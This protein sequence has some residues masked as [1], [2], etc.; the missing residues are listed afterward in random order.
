MKTF[1]TLMTFLG[2]LLAYGGEGFY[3]KSE[4]PQTLLP[5]WE[6]TFLISTT[7][8]D[9]IGSAFVFKKIADIDPFKVQL[10]LLASDHVI[11]A[12]CGSKIGHCDKLTLSASVGVDLNTFH[13]V[14]MDSRQLSETGVDIIHREFQADLSM[15][16]IVVDKKKY[17]HIEPI[18]FVENC[19][20]SIGQEIFILGFPATADRT[21]SDSLPISNKHLVIRRFS[22]GYVVGHF[23]SDSNLDDKTNYWTGTTADAL[24]SNSGGPALLS[25]GRFF[26][27]VDSASISEENG[28]KYTGDENV[29]SMD[30][31]SLVTR[32][33]L[34]KDFIE[35]KPL[36]FFSSIKNKK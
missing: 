6:S 20:L 14:I 9:G 11:R 27:V 3:P 12:L 17:K 32:C 5:A 22:K 24:E 26:G 30:W 2:A 33:E 18:P 7:S 23:R 15:L 35:Q 29:N 31:H 36:S 8:R 16:K 13:D 25:T 34:V 10:Y 28:Y 1:L 19:H 21:A 4:L